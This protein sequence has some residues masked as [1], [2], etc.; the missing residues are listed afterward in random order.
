MDCNHR[1]IAG[2]RDYVKLCQKCGTFLKKKIHIDR[3]TSLFIAWIIAIIVI[4]ALDF[5]IPKAHGFYQD[6]Q[7]FPNNYKL[8]EIRNT[9]RQKAKK[10]ITK[11]KYSGVHKQKQTQK[12]KKVCQN[13]K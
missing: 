4:I 2:P 10:S 3:F 5:I 11:S 6:Q 1:N 7:I 13:D 9:D 12:D 8:Y